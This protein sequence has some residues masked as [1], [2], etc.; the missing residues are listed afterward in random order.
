VVKC[1]KDAAT[2]ATVGDN[3]GVVAKDASKSAKNFFEKGF[4]SSFHKTE[5]RS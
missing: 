1:R 2:A 5:H 3:G 4:N